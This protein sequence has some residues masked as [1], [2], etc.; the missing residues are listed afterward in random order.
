M[1]FLTF[2]VLKM[3]GLQ[4]AGVERDSFD[5]HLIAR[6][7]I[8]PTWQSPA[9]MMDKDALINM[10]HPEI[11]DVNWQFPDLL[12]LCRRLPRRFAPRNDM[13]FVPDCII[14]AFKLNDN[15]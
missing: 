7:G 15:L 9:E 2:S 14:I 8:A 4:Y 1:D 13:L 10:A 11:F 12:L 6:R 5:P 3:I